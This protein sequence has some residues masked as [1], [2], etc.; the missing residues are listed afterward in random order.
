MLTK[1]PAGETALRSCRWR[2]STRLQYLFRL[3]HTYF[4]DDGK[5]LLPM[6]WVTPSGAGNRACAVDN[7]MFRPAIWLLEKA[8]ERLV[9]LRGWPAI[10]RARYGVLHDE[11]HEVLVAPPGIA[12]AHEREDLL[13]LS[14]SNGG[15]QLVA[16]AV[17]P[18]ALGEQVAGDLVGLDPHVDGAHDF[19]GLQFRLVCE[20]KRCISLTDVDWAVFLVELAK[21]P[22]VRN[23]FFGHIPES[24]GPWETYYASA[25]LQ[26]T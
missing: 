24:S 7:Q 23:A 5:Q 19:P 17:L 6:L 1:G 4:R 26:Q 13:A 10:E 8:A 11:M 20:C 18:L 14:Y 9:V 22:C 12:E 16:V 25:V 21:V 15:W 2:I 3:W